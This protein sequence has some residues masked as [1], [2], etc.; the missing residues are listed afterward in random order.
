MTGLD[1]RDGEALAKR[2]IIFG[3]DGDHD[4]FDW[5]KTTTNLQTRYVVKGDWKL[6][7]NVGKPNELYNVTEDPWEKKNLFD[8]KP[9]KV[10]E[11]TADLDAWWK[12]E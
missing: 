2:D 12:P 4:M 9:D 10:K 7:D 8:K 3:Y 6:L 11:L 5:K 1:L